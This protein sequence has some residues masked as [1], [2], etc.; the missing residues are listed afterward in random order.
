MIYKNAL[1]VTHDKEFIGYIEID[2]QTGNILNIKKGKT[3]KKGIDCTNK[4][5]M[6]G[7]ID[8]HTHGGYGL[9]FTDIDQK[10]FD[11]NWKEYESNLSK[12]GVVG[13]FGASVT[14]S[15]DRLKNIALSFRKAINKYEDTLLG[16]Y[17]E[18]PFI[19]IEK[20]GAHDK[21]LIKPID[22]D[23]LNW[24]KNN[25]FNKLIIVI[26]AENNDLD[27]LKKYSD[28]FE[29][30]I[31]HSNAYNLSKN[32]MINNFS[33]VTHLYNACS[34]FHHRNDSIVN[35][36]LTYKP[37]PNNFSV[38]II[39]DGMHTS[40]DVLEFTYKNIEKHNLTIVSDS[41]AQKGLSDGYYML[42]SLETE[43]KGDLFYLKNT[44]TISGSGK[45]YNR[46]V[47]NFKKAC[48]PTWSELV[49]F[50]SYNIAK[51]YGLLDK[52]GTIKENKKANF[53]LIDKDINVELFYKNGELIYK[54]QD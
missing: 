49:Y 2:E 36:I 21:T 42:G 22:E 8:S 9:D 1:I 5:I 25:F 46:I 47:D 48:N 4:I 40:N 53:I 13:V 31:G 45:P 34:S 38:E 33:R 51:K 18:G 41:L 35:T 44:N 28:I 16:W 6:P 11:K 29:Y 20:K 27:L 30:S 17:M 26:A 39:G 24:L 37:L 10:D 54:K 14:V 32:G 3:T 7:F 12:E 43:K 19:S 52:Y 15:T 50:T 23:I